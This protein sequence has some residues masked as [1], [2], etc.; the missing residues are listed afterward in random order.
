MVNDMDFKTA[1]KL[2]TYISKDYAEDIFGLLVNYQDISASEAASRL[3][4]H[5]KTVQEFLEAMASLGMIQQDEVTEGKRPY[6][7]YSLK[8][9]RIVM[10]IDLSTIKRT[11]SSDALKRKI[12]EKK[13]TAA[14]FSLSRKGDSINSVIIWAGEGRDRTERKIKLTLS[15][16]LFLYHLPFPNTEYMSISDIMQKAG[17]DESLS[18]EILDIVSD[19]EKYHVVDIYPS[20]A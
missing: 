2:G 19:L 14:R 4:L 6:Y 16:G 5:I 11:D 17:I 7:R 20:V 8:N 15:Q 12:R 1:A 18:P 3:N 9:Q 10:D 13:N